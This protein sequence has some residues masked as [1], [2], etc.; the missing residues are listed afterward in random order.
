[1]YLSFILPEKPPMKKML[2][3]LS[4]L[5]L[6]HANGSAQTG[7]VELPFTD[8]G[9]LHSAG[10]YVPPDYDATRKWPLII[11][12]HGGG[13]SGDPRLDAASWAAR[14]PIGNTIKSHPGWFPA[15]VLMPRCPPGKI[16]AP[17]PKDPIQ[18]PWR[19]RHHGSDPA[20]DAA[21]L[22]TAAID[23]AVAQYAIDENRITMMGHSMGG[24][25][26]TLYAPLHAD[27]IAAIAPSA[28]SAIIVPENAP[29]LA[30]MGVW[31][32]QGENDTISTSDLA[33]KMV[34]AIKQAGG[35]V[36]YTELAGVGHNS[37]KPMLENEAVFEWLL[38]QRLKR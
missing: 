22:V 34:A 27:R 26:T 36:R 32:F 31:M 7:F 15:L 28:G 21:D 19:L 12:L 37:L 2:T 16:W 6:L 13:G 10:L 30:R 23:Q 29:I 14:T 5:L 38:G 11:F 17:G 4:L 20:P 8:E 1:M 35:E 24:E 3:A 18:S 33:K 9:E 25:G